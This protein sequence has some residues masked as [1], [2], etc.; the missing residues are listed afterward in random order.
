MMVMGS[1]FRLIRDQ[2]TKKKLE[3]S[4]LTR[5]R[6]L[7]NFNKVLELDQVVKENRRVLDC[8]N[9]KINQHH[10]K[11]K[12]WKLGKEEV[13]EFVL[14]ENLELE[15][16][17]KIGTQ[18]YE[19]A[20]QKLRFL[21]NLLANIADPIFTTEVP[22]IKSL[23]ISP[24]L[25]Q[26]RLIDKQSVLM[27]FLS[28]SHKQ[29]YDLV[30]TPSIGLS[31][32]LRK[33]FPNK[34]FAQVAAK[35][36]LKVL[37]PEPIFAIIPSYFKEKLA[38]V[39]LKL[40][41]YGTYFNHKLEQSEIFSLIAF[42][43]DKNSKISEEALITDAL[44]LLSSYF[45]SISQFN[46]PASS[47]SHYASHQIDFAIKSSQKEEGNKEEEEEEYTK[48]CTFSNYSTYLSHKAQ[49]QL[50]NKETPR[51]LSVKIKNFFTL[52]T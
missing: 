36:K 33:I 21:F 48:L 44:T 11:I 41:C 5:G 19:D 32:L 10:E 8:L 34:C 3:E 35:K 38:K 20:L 51:I 47:L 28:F 50:T 25:A 52:F 1:E 30:Q 22:L 12:H 15:R 42:T 18:D 2:S 43:D 17:K 14:K 39:P 24:I 7:E 37:L 46:R 13:P 49:I 4:E 26:Q 23:K 27:Q 45:P 16:K 29:G 6:T 9:E 31:S 40:A